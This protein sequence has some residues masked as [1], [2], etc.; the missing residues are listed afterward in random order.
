MREL[1]GAAGGVEIGDVAPFDGMFK[2]R[3]GRTEDNLVRTLESRR[4]GLQK[5]SRARIAMRLKKDA[6]LAAADGAGHLDGTLHLRRMMRI[7]G[8]HLIRV[9]P[10]RNRPNRLKTA[11]RKRGDDSGKR[12]KN[13]F[14]TVSAPQRNFNCRPGVLAVVRR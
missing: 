6:Q 4:K 1:I 3:V 11:V 9:C 14:E 12:L 10:L 13:G 2:G 8:N 7:V 5:R